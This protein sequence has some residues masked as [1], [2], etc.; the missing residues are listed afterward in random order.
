MFAF[1]LYEL[2]ERELGWRFT[3]RC[4][5]IGSDRHPRTSVNFVVAFVFPVN[6][7]IRVTRFVL[8]TW[9]ISYWSLISCEY[10]LLSSIKSWFPTRARVF[11]NDG[12]WWKF[13]KFQKNLE[14]F[15]FISKFRIEYILMKRNQWWDVF[16]GS[17]L[18][19]PGGT[20]V[21]G[22]PPARQTKTIAKPARLG[23]RTPVLLTMK[24]LF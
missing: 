7:Y 13:Q 18:R 10:Q 14:K 23:P 4:H 20:P 9:K 21:D 17:A 6:F 3:A 22:L 8:L 2:S 24:I 15:I 12:K 16:V 5:Q 11:Q 19:V 1:L